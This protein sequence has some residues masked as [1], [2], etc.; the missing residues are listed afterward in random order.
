MSDEIN[1]WKPPVIYDIYT[2][3]HRIATQHDIDEMGAAIKALI[4]LHTAAKRAM[5]DCDTA[6]EALR[7]RPVG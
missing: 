4:V 5:A 1:G 7:K 2:D 3:S 6:L